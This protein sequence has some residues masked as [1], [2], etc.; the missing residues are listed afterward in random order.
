MISRRVG[1]KTL[2]GFE[3]LIF[4]GSR[5]AYRIIL[6]LARLRRR[7][8]SYHSDPAAVAG[9]ST[10]VFIVIYQKERPPA[11]I[12]GRSMDLDNVCFSLVCARLMNTF[13][14]QEP[15]L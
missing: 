8:T 1:T 3:R 6:K 15:P 2:R 12:S 14:I 11:R 7:L 10:I 9:S 5:A 4:A 13:F